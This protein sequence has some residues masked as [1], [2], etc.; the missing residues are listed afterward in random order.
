M[1]RMQCSRC[2][3][4]AAGLQGYYCDLCGEWCCKECISISNANW[5]RI[6]EHVCSRC[7]G[8]ASDEPTPPLPT[9]GRCAGRSKRGPTTSG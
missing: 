9:K 7:A 1:S 4:L 2:E 6:E 3:Q 8:V 5:A